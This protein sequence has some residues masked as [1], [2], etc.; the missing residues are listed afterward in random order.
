MANGVSWADCPLLESVPGKVSG[1]WVFKGTRLPAS[2][3][4]ANLKSGTLDE[5]V[6][7]YPSVS[8][9]TLEAFLDYLA[10]QADLAA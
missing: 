9:E 4:L 10:A 2:V 1:A 6:E 8:R 5:L 3:I 7:D